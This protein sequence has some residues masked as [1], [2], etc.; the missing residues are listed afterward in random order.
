ML[1]NLKRGW[2]KMKFEKAVKAMKEGK[3][4]RRTCQIRG[5]YVDLEGDNFVHHN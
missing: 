3:K 1:K 4:V 2:N 5:I